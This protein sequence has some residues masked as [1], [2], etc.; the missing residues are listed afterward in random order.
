MDT[1]RFVWKLSTACRRCPS[2]RLGIDPDSRLA[3]EAAKEA[4][5][6]HDRAAIPANSAGSS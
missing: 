2:E 4:S 3:Q 5:A 1:A 6:D